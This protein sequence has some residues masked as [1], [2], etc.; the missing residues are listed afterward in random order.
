MSSIDITERLEG[1]TI[2]SDRA[3]ERT[4]AA[5]VSRADVA[6][7]P[8]PAA[9][10]LLAACLVLLSLIAAASFTEPGRSVAEAAG[11]LIGISSEPM[12]IGPNDQVTVGFR[13]AKGAVINCPDGEPF[14]Q[15]LTGGEGIGP[16]ACPDGSVPAAIAEQQATIDA[17]QKASPKTP[18][19]ELEFEQTIEYYVI[20]ER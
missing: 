13:D 14:T 9:R 2:G 20:Y 15:T 16:L 3:M 12:V 8:R 1:L 6:A 11:D 10:R 17:A 5:I 7:R 18:P 4:A 19:H